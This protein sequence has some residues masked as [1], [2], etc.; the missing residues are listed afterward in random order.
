ME[1]RKGGRKKGGNSK[2]ITLLKDKVS[3][4]YHQWI[5]RAHPTLVK[6]ATVTHSRRHITGK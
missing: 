5:S 2:D 1:G 4:L 3:V 6:K